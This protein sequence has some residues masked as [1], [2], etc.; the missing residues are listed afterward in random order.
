MLS[1]ARTLQRPMRGFARQG[2]DVLQ[3]DANMMDL[4]A[5]TLGY[6]A[7]HCRGAAGVLDAEA[8]SP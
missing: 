2:P 4:K 6:L 5:I 1:E 7:K 3:K 8:V